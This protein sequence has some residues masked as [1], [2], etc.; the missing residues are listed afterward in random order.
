MRYALCTV[1]SLAFTSAPLAMRSR[2]RR[3]SLS[4]AALISC[5]FSLACS[6]APGF[7]AFIVLAGC[8]LG[9]AV[10]GAGEVTCRDGLE[11]AA[12]SPPQASVAKA[13]AAKTANER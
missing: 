12:P 8:G 1:L 11:V 10:E 13:T 7:R 9:Q 5:W 6:L 2:A 4:Q 3:R